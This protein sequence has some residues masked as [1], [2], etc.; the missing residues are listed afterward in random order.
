MFNESPAN[1]Y[2]AV[3]FTLP[4]Q[5]PTTASCLGTIL[6]STAVGNGSAT[7]LNHFVNAEYSARYF[8]SQAYQKTATSTL[9]YIQLLLTEVLNSDRIRLHCSAGDASKS[10]VA[11]S[12]LDIIPA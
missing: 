11:S 2:A 5:G 10:S 12:Q 9:G 4:C 7:M 6:A 8:F 1:F 3:T